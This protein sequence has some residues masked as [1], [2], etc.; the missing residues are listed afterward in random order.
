VLVYN[1]PCHTL[2]ITFHWIA[3]LT[4]RDF[5]GFPSLQE[6][7]CT[8]RALKPEVKL[9]AL[10]MYRLPEQRLLA[11]MNV[12]T[13]ECVTLG[14]FASCV[15]ERTDTKTSKLKVLVAD[16]NEGESSEFKPP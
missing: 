1:V 2:E 4:S 14:D 9:L 16:L 5:K 11:S 13:K 3:G 6:V 15:V 12:M 10:Q 8:G 7:E